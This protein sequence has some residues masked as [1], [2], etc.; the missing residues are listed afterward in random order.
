MFRLSLTYLKLPPKLTTPS[1]ITKQ[2][3]QGLITQILGAI[4]QET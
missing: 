3:S 2:M 4:W 1:P